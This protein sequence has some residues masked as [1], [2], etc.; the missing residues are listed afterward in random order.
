[1]LLTPR[2]WERQMNQRCLRKYERPQRVRR[3]SSWD[4]FLA[5][6]F[7]QLTF[8]E[9]LR[10]IEACLRAAPDKLYHMG[11]RGQMS[12]STLADANE[13]R[14]CGVWRQAYDEVLFLFVGDA[15]EVATLVHRPA[16]AWYVRGREL[17]RKQHK[18]LMLLDEGGDSR[19]PIQN[20]ADRGPEESARPGFRNRPAHGRGP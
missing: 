15:D 1:M 9:S 11:F 6:A 19:V 2:T 16:A 10:D 18:L 17:D 20:R 14:D 8:R 5:M 12:R 3:F 4:Q 13:S 7:A